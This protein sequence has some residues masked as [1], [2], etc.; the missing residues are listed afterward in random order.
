VEDLSSLQLCPNNV[1]LL[2]D[3]RLI[4]VRG[5][6]DRTSVAHSQAS[7][8]QV[9]F[10]HNIATRDGTCILTGEP[11]ED[12][13]AC[14]FIP[15]AKGDDVCISP[16]L[17]SIIAASNSPHSC[18]QYIV[19]FSEFRGD[20]ESDLLDDICDPRNGILL[21][22]GLHGAFGRGD[23]VFMKVRYSPMFSFMVIHTFA[24]R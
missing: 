10:T 14:H 2:V 12:C 20:S 1:W 22:S 23:I 8:T 15:H 16:R 24:L 18:L 17:P 13:Q 7:T 19:S 21:H 3:P 6:D 5:I 4:D 11:P 9:Q